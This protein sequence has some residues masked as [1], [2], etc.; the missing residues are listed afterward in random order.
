MQRACATFQHAQMSTPSA[1]PALTPV[2]APVVQQVTFQALITP[3]A[4]VCTLQQA[5]FFNCPLKA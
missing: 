3:L 5:T 4:M 1:Q 2:L